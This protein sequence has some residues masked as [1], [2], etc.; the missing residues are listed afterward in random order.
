MSARVTLP[1]CKQALSCSGGMGEERFSPVRVSKLE[2]ELSAAVS[3]EV[4]H[5]EVHSTKLPCTHS[6]ESTSPVL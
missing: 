3:L 5:D 6:S 1:P 4:V 2:H